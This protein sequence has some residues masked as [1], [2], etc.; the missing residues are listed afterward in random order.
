MA[1]YGWM[2]A[3]DVLALNKPS[4]T[5]EITLPDSAFYDKEVE[6]TDD[7]GNVIGMETV[8]PPISGQWPAC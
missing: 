3:S 1:C 4:T 8:R 6:V 7:D 2:A 5:V